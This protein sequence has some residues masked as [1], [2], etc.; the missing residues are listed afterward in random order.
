MDTKYTSIYDAV[1]KRHSKQLVDFGPT[2]KGVGWRDQQAQTIRFQQLIK[3]FPE[4]SGF[5]LNDYGCGCAAFYGF[6]ENEGYNLDYAGH[7]ITPEMIAAARELYADRPNVELSVASTPTR[8]AD[9][10]IACGVLHLKLDFNENQWLDYVFELLDDMDSKSRG[11]F[12]F[13]SLTKYSDPERMESELY[14]PDPAVFFERCKTRYSRNVALLH[15]YE[16]YEFT[17]IVRKA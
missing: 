1:S 6:L 2:A 3:L 8:V 7:D 14:Y 13:N 15:D 17:I 11:G 5:S 9:F 16:L 10:S 4:P 12:A